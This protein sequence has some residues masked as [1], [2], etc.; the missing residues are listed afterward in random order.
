MGPNVSEREN[1]LPAALGW[2][3]DNLRVHAAF[4]LILNR[5]LSLR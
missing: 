2:T 1:Q 5:F 4:C 3:S